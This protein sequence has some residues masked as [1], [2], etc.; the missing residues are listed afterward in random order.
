MKNSMVMSQGQFNEM[1]R[2]M[3]ELKTKSRQEIERLLIENQD[4]KENSRHREEELESAVRDKDDEIKNMRNMFDK[5]MAIYKQKLEFKDVQA[6]QL[7]SQLDESR[8]SHE[9]MVKAIENKARESYDGK[10]IA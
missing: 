2:Q 5:E 7:K 8:K 4:L 6:T 9:Q 1:Q 3:D 10:E